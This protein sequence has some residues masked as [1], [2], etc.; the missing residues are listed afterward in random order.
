MPEADFI[1][2]GSLLVS[3]F[4]AATLLPGGSEA[5]LAGLLLLRPELTLPA[6]LLA[7]LGNTAGGM[8]T[9]ALGRLLPRKELPPRL[10]LVR[11][12]GSVSLV[13]S[14]LPLLGDGLCAAAGLLRLN[15]FAC[16]V[17]M[18]IGKGARY[19]VLAWALT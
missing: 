12:Y 10:E 14:W 11:R 17:W 5:A 7:T 3:A 6:I 8:S 16:L 13:L 4:L 15:G 1:L 9:Y 18:A 19:L 2:L